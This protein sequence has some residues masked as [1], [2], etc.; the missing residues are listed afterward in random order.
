[1]SNTISGTKGIVY[2]YKIVD[3]TT[4]KT[5]TIKELIAKYKK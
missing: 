4:G 5:I 2:L 3:V 1:M